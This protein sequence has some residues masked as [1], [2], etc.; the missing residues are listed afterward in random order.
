MNLNDVNRGIVPHKKRK[1][2]GRGPGSGHGKTAG[3]G[4][5]GARSR[6]GW[7]A[8]LGFEGGQVPLIRRIPKRGFNNKRFATQIAAV[9]VAVL[10]KEFA[11]GDEVTPD[12]LQSRGLLKGVFQELKIL[13]DGELSKTLRVSAHRFS[14]QAKEKIEKAGGQV[15]VLPGRAPVVKNVKSNRKTQ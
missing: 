14:R 2:V 3:R 10:E 12:V 15:V 6:S 8:K 4:H 11:T 5:K 1:R 7:R 9:N 13:G